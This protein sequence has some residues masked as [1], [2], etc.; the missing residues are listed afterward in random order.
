MPWPRKLADSTARSACCAGSAGRNWRNWETWRVTWH[1][2]EGRWAFR[3]GSQVRWTYCDSIRYC[4]I[5]SEARHG[6]RVARHDDGV[7]AA[8][9]NL[10][11][12]H[13]P[14]ELDLKTP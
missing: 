3:F 9:V 4:A 5:A 6:L 13:R 12:F 2:V 7:F 11:E 8:D 1:L 10:H 14:G